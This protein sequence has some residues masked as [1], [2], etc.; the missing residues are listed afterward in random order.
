MLK[1]LLDESQN[2]PPYR[3]DA[4]QQDQQNGCCH[5][6]GAGDIGSFELFKTVCDRIGADSQ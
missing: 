1:T 2:V 4:D 3:G 5:Q 6:A